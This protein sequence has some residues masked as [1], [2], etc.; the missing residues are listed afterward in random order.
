VRTC[1]GQQARQEAASAID[2]IEDF[3]YSVGLHRRR[4]STGACSLSMLER[5]SA[6]ARQM[7]VVLIAHSWIKTLQ[8]PRLATTTT[9]TK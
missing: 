2:Q 9:D 4:S 1:C 6:N 8:E 5:L 7:H 3:G